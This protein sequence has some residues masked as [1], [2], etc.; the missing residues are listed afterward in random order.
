[1]LIHALARIDLSLPV[2]A[3]SLIETPSPSIRVTG[4]SSES[5]SPLP[6]NRLSQPNFPLKQEK[7]RYSSSSANTNFFPSSSSSSAMAH[8]QNRSSSS[9]SS[10]S[11]FY[12][13]GSST[14]NS[15]ATTP[16]QPGL[17][18]VTEEDRRFDLS[19][20]IDVDSLIKKVDELVE[21]DV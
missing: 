15:M 18:F 3:T 17:R 20:S 4:V 12:L 6:F 16:T 1:M 13:H 2:L 21:T 5:I 9:S 11:N 8:N 7:R 19:T 14:S 10:V